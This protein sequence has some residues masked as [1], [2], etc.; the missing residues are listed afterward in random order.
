MRQL[1]DIIKYWNSF[2]FDKREM[3]KPIYLWDCFSINN[4]SIQDLGEYIKEIADVLNAYRRNNP[5]YQY[6][7]NLDENVEIVVPYEM[8][9][10]S[11]LYLIRCA[12]I[13]R[14]SDDWDLVYLDEFNTPLGLENY[15]REY[16]GGLIALAERGLSRLPLDNEDEP[17]KHYC[18]RILAEAG[19]PLR[20]LQSGRSKV[21]QGLRN[22][23]YLR[24][25]G[26]PYRMYEKVLRD[27]IAN[28]S[29]IKRDGPNFWLPG[30][31][32]G[33]RMFFKMGLN[34]LERVSSEYTK[35]NGEVSEIELLKEFGFENP[36]EEAVDYIFRNK[37]P[38]SFSIP[39]QTKIPQTQP[40]SMFTRSAETVNPPKWNYNTAKTTMCTNNSG[41]KPID[42]AI[43]HGIK[44][45]VVMKLLRDAGVMV[46]T[47]MSMVDADEFKKIEQKVAEEKRKAEERSQKLIRDNAPAPA[48]SSL[49]P[50]ATLIRNGKFV[51]N[52]SNNIPNAENSNL[53]YDKI[54]KGTHVIHQ[55]YGRGV[56]DNVYGSGG[57]ACIVVRF[58]NERSTRSFLQRVALKALQIIE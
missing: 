17:T 52:N 44:V 47:H 15:G 58:D 6:D 7:E 38:L 22:I 56:V 36:S 20:S 9:I 50:K 35:R 10:Y 42:W 19:F 12:L 5:L 39:K 33:C 43:Q 1:S 27:F 11:I 34:L 21:V 13:C 3:Q 4:C 32:S 29:L 2:S 16:W 25:G 46:R 54:H 28:Y 26:L 40:K 8:K 18:A 53:Q 30:G 48:I 49:T 55:N 45:D 41:I 37:T 31:K 51:G 23:W 24:S 14:L 57:N